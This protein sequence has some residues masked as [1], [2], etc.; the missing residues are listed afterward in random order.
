MSWFSR[1]TWYTPKPL[2]LGIGA[3]VS[4]LLYCSSRQIG[5]AALSPAFWWSMQTK[6]NLLLFIENDFLSQFLYQYFTLCCT[7]IVVHHCICCRRERGADLPCHLV[8]SAP[9]ALPWRHAVLEPSF[10]QG[11]TWG[12]PT[13]TPS[14]LI[15]MGYARGPG[16]WMTWLLTV[17]LNKTR[18]PESQIPPL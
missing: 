8:Q 15:S 16:K 9:Q 3:I 10:T 5:I 13:P 17:N 1:N 6:R 7:F 11:R 12:C 4:H 14:E 18:P 2:P